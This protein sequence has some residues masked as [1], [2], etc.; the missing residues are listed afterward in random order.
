[1]GDLSAVLDFYT[2][3]VAIGRPVAT[4]PVAPNCGDRPNFILYGL[5]VSPPNCQ[6]PILPSDGAANKRESF[7]NPPPASASRGATGPPLLEN[8]LEF[9]LVIAVIQDRP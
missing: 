9:N 6:F 8:T 4:A 2:S 1:M 3:R 7:G 5:V